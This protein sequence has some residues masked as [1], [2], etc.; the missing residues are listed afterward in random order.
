MNQD[1]VSQENGKKSLK[2][3]TRVDKRWFTVAN[4][5]QT[6]FSLSGF[7]VI[8]TICWFPI[9]CF[10]ELLCWFFRHL[11]LKALLVASQTSHHWILV[12]SMIVLMKSYQMWDDIVQN[13]VKFS[14]LKVTSLRRMEGDWLPLQRAVA[15]LKLFLFMATLDLMPPWWP[16]EA[17]VLS[18]NNWGWDH[19][20]QYQTG[21][22]ST[23]LKIATKLKN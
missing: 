2:S 21:W 22:L 20:N 5:T 19:P 9:H 17:I 18:L 16:S 14:Y 13:S 1:L 3:I 12:F 6:A 23:S 10:I 15:D 4:E 8:S 7:K 11:K